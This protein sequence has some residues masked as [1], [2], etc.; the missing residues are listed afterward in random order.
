[1][2]IKVHDVLC[3]DCSLHYSGSEELFTTEDAN[4]C[5]CCGDALEV[6][7]EDIEFFTIEIDYEGEMVEPAWTVSSLFVQRPDGLVM[8]F[9]PN[10]GEDGDEG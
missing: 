2:E 9:G 5:A 7:A 4:E 3:S 8:G 10:E 6:P 1:M